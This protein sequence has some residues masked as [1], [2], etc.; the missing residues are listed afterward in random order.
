MATAAKYLAGPIS[1]IAAYLC[2]LNQFNGDL[3]KAKNE[4]KTRL[5]EVSERK[6]QAAG[7]TEEITLPVKNWLDY[8][9]TIL[10]DVQKLEREVEGGAKKC[11]HVSLR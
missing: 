4:L 11:F 1:R 10:A 6:E 2:C 7:R 5:K 8:V 3:E 9:E